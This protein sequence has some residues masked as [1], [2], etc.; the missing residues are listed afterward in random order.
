MTACF[1]SAQQTIDETRCVVSIEYIVS[2]PYISML[3][4]RHYVQFVFVSAT[5]YFFYAL[6]IT[7]IIQKQRIHTLKLVALVAAA[8]A[9]V[10]L[11]LSY[12]A[13]LVFARK[14]RYQHMLL[15]FVIHFVCELYY[16]YCY[17]YYHCTSTI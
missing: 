11:L 2:C 6:T 13:A 1:K 10:S 4:Q 5:S 14:R 8:A 15:P 16:Y 7:P 3:Q 12:H 9:W 17:H